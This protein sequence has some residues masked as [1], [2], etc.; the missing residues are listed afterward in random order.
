LG[1]NYIELGLSSVGSFGTATGKPGGFVGGTPPGSHPDSVGFTLDVDGF[2]S[3]QDKAL[4]FYVPDAPEERWS[5]GFDNTNYASFSALNG[6]SSNAG[7]LTGVSIAD[8]SSGNTLKGTFVAVVGDVLKVEQVHTFG[9]NDKYYKTTVT[10]TNVSDV[11]QS[12][13]EFMRS[14]DPDGT[15]SVGG[16]NTT[17]NTILGQFASDTFSSVTA[18]SLEGDAYQVQTGSRAVTYYYS[19]D[20]RSVVYTGGFKNP[21]PYDFAEANQPTKFATTADDAIGIIFK[22]GDLAPHSSVTFSYY[23]GATTDDNP[24]LIEEETGARPIKTLA[25][26]NAFITKFNSVLQSEQYKQWM[27]LAGNVASIVGL[28][29][30]STAVNFLGAA[31]KAYQGD[32]FGLGMSVVQAAGDG[33]MALGA[34]SKIGFLYAAGAAVSTIGYVADL[35]SKTDWS[36]PGGTLRYAVDHP[37]ET[38]VELAKATVEVGSHVIATIAGSFGGFLGIVRK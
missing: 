6:D 7:G 20:P 18:A 16:N 12:N 9:V 13:V 27:E 37:V 29:A 19:S 22:A 11:A 21:N 1:G 8:G 24:I 38:A 3:G 4:D 34:K 14:F 10:L 25:S 36:D 15:R 17:V 30:V 2:G 33:L 32:L 28:K 31:T 26:T 5:V 23:T 35:A